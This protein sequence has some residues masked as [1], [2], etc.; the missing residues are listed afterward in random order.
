MKPKKKTK[1]LRDGEGDAIK[2]LESRILKRL[3]ERAERFRRELSTTGL[4]KYSS[5]QDH[6]TLTGQGEA[7]DRTASTRI[8]RPDPK[9]I[10][11]KKI[12]DFAKDPFQ[13]DPF[14][15][16]DPGNFARDNFS[17]DN[18]DRND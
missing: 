13:K 4:E 14:D 15:K 6:V 10:A 18:F 12:E 11:G 7:H 5:E 17:R 9:G 16:G 8:V 2:R 3:S 1:Q